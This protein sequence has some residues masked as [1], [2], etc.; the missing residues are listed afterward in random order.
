MYKKKLF[1]DESGKASL[2]S[3]DNFIL[4]GVVVEQ[5]YKTVVEGYFNFIKGKYH[6]DINKPY[7]SY[8]IYEHPHTRLSD[9]NLKKLSFELSDFISNIPVDIKI[10]EVNKKIFYKI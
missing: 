6:I 9:S 4:T 8:H 7:H 1:L 10:I 5:R 3:D 2:I